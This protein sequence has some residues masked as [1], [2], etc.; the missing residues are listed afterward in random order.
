MTEQAVL[1]LLIPVHKTQTKQ[2][3]IAEERQIEESSMSLSSSSGTIQPRIKITM[4]NSI[5]MIV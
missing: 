4:V 3:R 5:Y 2:G 1:Q